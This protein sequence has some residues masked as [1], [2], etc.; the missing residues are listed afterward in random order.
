M[1]K[2]RCKDVHVAFRDVVMGDIEGLA[3][4]LGM[5]VGTLYNKANIN[6]TSHHKPTLAEAVLVTLLTGN[7]KILH[8]FAAMVGD[9]CYSL[10]DMSTC[11]TD[12][13]LTHL[14]KIEKESGKFYETVEAALR[15]DNRISRKEYQEIEKEAYLWISSILETLARVKEMAGE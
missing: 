7:K 2:G 14:L 13:L 15:N 12:A 4:K 9:V 11:S 8:A 10:P 3:A 5:P 1:G 6:E